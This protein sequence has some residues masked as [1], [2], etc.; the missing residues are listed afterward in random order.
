MGLQ[1][2]SVKPTLP[3]RHVAANFQM[4]SSV[5]QL[6]Q[7]LA[8][9]SYEAGHFGDDGSKEAE[10]RVRKSRKGRLMIW[11]H[12]RVDKLHSIMS[13]L[14]ART[15]I[16]PHIADFRSR[17]SRYVQPFISTRKKVYAMQFGR[18]WVRRQGRIWVVRSFGRCDVDIELLAVFGVL[19]SGV[20]ISIM[21]IKKHPPR[22]HLAVVWA[23]T[24]MEHVKILL[25]NQ[26]AVGE[27]WPA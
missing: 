1:W 10:T 18:S 15:G 9:G 8:S 24:G 6:P 27:G 23:V 21:A 26:E 22:S 16:W 13:E 25:F 3:I 14:G 17:R 2:C 11:R 19:C 12:R 20:L 4:L 5:A 7:H